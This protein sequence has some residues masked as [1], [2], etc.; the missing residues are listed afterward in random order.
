MLK[1]LLPSWPSGYFWGG[2]YYYICAMEERIE[3]TVVQGLKDREGDPEERER[4]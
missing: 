1:D 3:F 2:E 4:T